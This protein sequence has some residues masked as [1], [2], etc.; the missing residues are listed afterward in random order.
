MDEKR[1][2]STPERRSPVDTA[3]HEGKTDMS[4]LHTAILTGALALSLLLAACGAQA[5]GPA[6]GGNTNPPAAG[7]GGIAYNELKYDVVSEEAA[8][9]PVVDWLN[10]NREKGG[11]TTI[12]EGDS[13]YLVIAAGEKPTGGYDVEVVSVG[14]SEGKVEVVYRVTSPAADAMVTQA[15]TYPVKVLKVNTFDLPVEFKAEN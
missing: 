3:K 1:T 14:D 13:V 15:L 2:A 6:A 9:A 4:K 10:A 12:K 5:P 7:S 11:T 8:P